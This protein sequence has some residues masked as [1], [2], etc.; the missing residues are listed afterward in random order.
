MK[1]LLSSIDCRPPRKG[2]AMNISECENLSE[3][4]T[5]ETQRRGACTHPTL[6]ER[7][8]AYIVGLLEDTEAK[9]IEDHLLDCRSCREFFSSVLSMRGEARKMNATRIG[10]DESTANGT[11]VLRLAD[12][13]KEWS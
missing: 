1:R 3:Q 10:T 8:S 9:E 4:E 12:F 13:R 7:L 6:G 2:Q 5:G 11:K